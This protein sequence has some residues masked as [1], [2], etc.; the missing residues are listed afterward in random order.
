MA[1]RRFSA[2]RVGGVAIIS[3]LGA[4]G[5]LWVSGIILGIATA[6]GWVGQIIHVAWNGADIN[7]L[8]G[9][10][11]VAGCVIPPL[12]AVLFWVV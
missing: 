7:T 9:I 2:D 11:E 10:V 8:S 5:F 6:I 4:F 3:A 12:G 1:R